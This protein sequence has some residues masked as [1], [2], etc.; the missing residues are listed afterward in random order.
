MY[1]L[2]VKRQGGKTGNTQ[3]LALGQISQL[4]CRLLTV[5]VVVVHDG[6]VV[7]A[8]LL[9]QHHQSLKPHGRFTYFFLARLVYF[10]W[11][12]RMSSCHV[13]TCLLRR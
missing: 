6:D 13:F 2:V 8:K 1:I 11:V 10:R 3:F 12:L 7:P 5:S 9:Q 4:F